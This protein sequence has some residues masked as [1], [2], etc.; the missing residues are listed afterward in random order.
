MDEGPARD[1]QRGRLQLRRGGHR[2][3][4]PRQRPLHVLERRAVQRRCAGGLLSRQV[5]E[6]RAGDRRVQEHPDALP[7]DVHPGHVPRQP[8]AD[9]QSRPALGSVLPVHRRE[10]PPRL[11]SARRA[12]RRSTRTRRSARSIPAIRPVPM[13][14]TIRRGPISARASASPTIRSATARAAFAPV[15]ASS[16]T[17]RIRSRPT[18]PPTRGLSARWSRSPATRRTTWRI[19][20]PDAPTRSRRIRSTCRPTCSSSCRTRRSA[21]TRTSRTAGSSRGTSRSSARSCRPTCVRVGYAGSKGDRLAMGR[22][23]NAAVFAPGA[24]T[25]TTNQRRPLFPTTAPSRRSSRR[26]GRPTT[27]CSSRST[28]G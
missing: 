3:Q 27:R 22:E 28:S 24:T 12:V 16:T 23:L 13:A 18:A 21:T 4:L 17:G 25:A 20:T 5:L 6:L 1:C 19:R 9:A 11:L 8:S 7:G 2:Q 15:T 26:A 10:Q 14:A